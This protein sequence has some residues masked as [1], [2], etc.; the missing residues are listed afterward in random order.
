VLFSVVVGVALIGVDRKQPLI[1][2]LNVADQTLS[3]TTQYIVRLA[4]YGLFAIAA[5]ASGTLSL[6][7]LGRLQVY[8]I[9]YVI[10]ALLVAL[11]VLPGLVSALT[12]IRASDMFRLTKE[13]L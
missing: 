5:N 12:P 2:M 7:E 9:A 8:L 13:A 1:D 3:K 10:V 6:E 11:W 4:P